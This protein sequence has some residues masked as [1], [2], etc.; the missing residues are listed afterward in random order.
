MT[1]RLILSQFTLPPLDVPS[2]LALAHA[3]L[4]A[5]PPNPPVHVMEA[6][7]EVKAAIKGPSKPSGERAATRARSRTP[8]PSIE[9]SI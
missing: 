9:G 4:S 8:G 5:I 7:A 3:L 2:M 1:E 6:A